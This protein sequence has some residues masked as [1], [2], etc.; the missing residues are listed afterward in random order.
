MRAAR[1]SA[2]IVC[3]ALAAASAA[4]AMKDPTQPPASLTEAPAEGLRA[5]PVLQ[6]VIIA[7]GSRAA[8]I[9]GERVEIGG[10]FRDAT[11]VRITEDEV[12]LR[13][14]GVMQ[15]LKMYPDVEKKPVKGPDAALSRPPVRSRLP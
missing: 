2:C 15:V 8:I 6:S 7:K 12:V 13:Q 10:R 11:V 1:A 9:D 14:D 4:A 3:F 5:R